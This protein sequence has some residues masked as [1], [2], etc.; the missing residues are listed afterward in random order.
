MFFRI[1]MSS[2]KK[3]LLRR[4]QTHS[5]EKSE[6]TSVLSSSQVR[7]NSPSLNNLGRGIQ[8]ADDIKVD[9]IIQYFVFYFHFDDGFAFSFERKRTRTF[10]RFSLFIFGLFDFCAYVHFFSTGRNQTKAVQ[11]TRIEQ[12]SSEINE[13]MSPLLA[14]SLTTTIT[15]SFTF[16]S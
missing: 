13:T 11:L 6:M 7:S 14:S 12:E 5:F 9:V 8:F 15:F 4:R 1:C 2:R 16:L 3:A 10:S